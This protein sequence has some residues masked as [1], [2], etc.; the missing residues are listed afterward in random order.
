MSRDL[1]RAFKKYGIKVMTSTSVESVDTSG[2]ALKVTVKTKKGEET[3]ECDQVLS[4]VG[5]VGNI[6]KL[7][8]E[9]LGVKTER[10]AIVIDAFGRTNVA[11][12]YAIGDVAGPPWLAHK[13]SHEGILCIEKIAGHDV[14]PMGTMGSSLPTSTTTWA[15]K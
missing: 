6:E 10:D 12:I 1:A 3:I 14:R 13:A 8:L 9:D 11:G 7:G 15:P 5:V 2:K 4:A